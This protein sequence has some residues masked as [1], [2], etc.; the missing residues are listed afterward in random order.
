MSR[1]VRR[2]NQHTERSGLY[3]LVACES[4]YGGTYYRKQWL[5]PGT[6]EFMLAWWHYHRD[7]GHGRFGVPRWFR[8]RFNRKVRREEECALIQVLNRGEFDVV[9]KRRVRDAAYAWF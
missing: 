4:R 7:R 3:D 6:R 1:T 9:V 2:K 8:A 5:E